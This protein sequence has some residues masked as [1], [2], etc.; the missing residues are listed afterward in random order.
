MK[1]VEAHN[2]DP[3]RLFTRNGWTVTCKNEGLCAS[4]KLDDHVETL[5]LFTHDQA[6]FP[7]VT[8][9]L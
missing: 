8:M 5:A 2:F 6:I 3:S 7:E 9:R 1:A 4:A